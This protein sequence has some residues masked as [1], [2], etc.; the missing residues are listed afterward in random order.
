MKSPYF[1]AER[2]AQVYFFTFA[3][4]NNVLRERSLLEPILFI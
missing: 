1:Q 2:N 4:I 3:E